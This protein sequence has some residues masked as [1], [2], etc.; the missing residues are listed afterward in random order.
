MARRLPLESFEPPDPEQ[1]RLALARQIDAHEEAKLA[2]FEQGYTAGWD[3]AV[4]AQDREIALLRAD[5]GRNLLGLSFT[6]A[7]A[8]AHLLAAVQPLLCGMVEK[9][10]PRLAHQAVGGMAAE[11]L[12]A[13]AHER[14]GQPLEVTVSPASRAAVE[15]MLDTG[16]D[17]PMAFVEEESL[18]AG[19]VY[20]RLGR[21]ERQLDLDGL[22]AAMSQALAE[23]LHPVGAIGGNREGD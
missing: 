7:E 10:L 16:T 6:Y 19:Q 14:G 23:A 2:A 22:I 1:E 3:D 12:S 5:L 13:I 17:L 15:E 11:L 8:R 18:G 4:A 21:V 20:L 9:V